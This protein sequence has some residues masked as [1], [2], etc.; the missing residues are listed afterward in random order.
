MSTTKKTNTSA[1]TRPRVIINTFLLLIAAVAFMVMSINFGGSI[2]ARG[3]NA[4]K[5]ISSAPG[6]CFDE[7]D[8]GQATRNEYICS[9][10]IDENGDGKPVANANDYALYA[11]NDTVLAESVVVQSISFAVMVVGSLFSLAFIVGAIVYW[12]HSRA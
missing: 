7:I 6:L 4:M 12:N 5:P 11:H 9:S 8:G 1:K 3:G 2:I 10:E